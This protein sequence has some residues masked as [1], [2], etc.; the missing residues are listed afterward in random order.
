MLRHLRWSFTLRRL[1]RFFVLCATLFP[2]ILAAQVPQQLLSRPSPFSTVRSPEDPLRPD[3][4]TTLIADPASSSLLLMPTGRTITSG[5]GS[6][7]LAAPYI[8]YG[9]FA[10]AQGL[11]ISAGGVYI[12]KNSSG[13]AQAYYSYLFV[14]DALWDDGTTSIALGAVLMFWGQEHVRRGE[15]NWDRVVVPGVF[16]VTTIGNQ[17]GALTLGVGFAD[18]AGGYGIGLDA[19]LLSGL[20]IGYE[21]LISRGIKVMTEHFIDALSGNT[22]HTFGARLF[23]ARGAFDIGLI[24]LPH[25]Q[26]IGRVLP[27]I[28]V[29]LLI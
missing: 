22:L 18:A 13:S 15:R 7:G 1:R 12:F 19:G 26:V 28:G 11:Q 3:S 9:A 5:H 23:A 2:A 10:V 20:G 4:A 21:A 25:G 29:S 14:K 27:V 6:I 8:P 17:H 24:V 16:A